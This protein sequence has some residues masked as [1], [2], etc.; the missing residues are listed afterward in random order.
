MYVTWDE[1]VES[2][3]FHLIETDTN[4]FYWNAIN[5]SLCNLSKVKVYMH[6]YLI[7][8][9][10]SYS[11]SYITINRITFSRLEDDELSK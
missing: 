4:E 2:G 9:Q 1:L 3:P 6:I 5:Y 7:L 10:S 8:F 11:Y